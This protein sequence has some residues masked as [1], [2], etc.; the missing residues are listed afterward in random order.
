MLGFTYSSCIGICIKAMQR[1]TRKESGYLKPELNLTV[2]VA[3]GI[4]S[5]TALIAY[6][7]FAIDVIC[8]RSLIVNINY[9]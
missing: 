6:Y 2:H 3:V 5:G 8:E 4:A 7:I 1:Q 9:Y